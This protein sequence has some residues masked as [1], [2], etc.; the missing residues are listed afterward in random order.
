MY[1]LSLYKSNRKKSEKSIV[2]QTKSQIAKK[3][4]KVLPLRLEVIQEI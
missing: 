4:K 3:A 2:S 1:R